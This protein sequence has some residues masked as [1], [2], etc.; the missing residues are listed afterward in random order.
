MDVGSRRSEGITGVY[1]PFLDARRLKSASA[2]STH[3]AGP[4]AT[5]CGL[6]P[7][8]GQGPIISLTLKL[9]A[10]RTQATPFF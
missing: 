7:C 9:Q 5:L 10:G 6:T 4:P 8:G 1:L 2:V 3:Q